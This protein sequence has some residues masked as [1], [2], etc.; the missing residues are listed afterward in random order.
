[1]PTWPAVVATPVPQLPPS[2]AGSVAALLQQYGS[3]R[4]T[5]GDAADAGLPGVGQGSMFMKQGRVLLALTVMSGV[6]VLTRALK[7]SFRYSSA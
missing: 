6:V 1:V 5:A 2:A 4:R 3:R 7:R